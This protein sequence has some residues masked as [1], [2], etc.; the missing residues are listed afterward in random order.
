MDGRSKALLGVFYRSER[1]LTYSDWL[2]HIEALL[3]HL[4]VEWDG[5]LILTGDM[6]IDMLQPRSPMTRQYQAVLDA[7]RFHQIIKQPTHITK[8][9]RTIINHIVTSHPQRVTHSGVIPC[10]GAVSDHDSVFPIP[11]TLQIHPE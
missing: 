9:S 11:T 4:T 1:I 10:A 3:D 7:F 2:E 8:T 5:L 6:N